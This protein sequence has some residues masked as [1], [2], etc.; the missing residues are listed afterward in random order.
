VTGAPEQRPVPLSRAPRSPTGLAYLLT[1]QLGSTTVTV[2]AATLTKL[3]ETRYL[4]WGKTRYTT[5]DPG[6]PHRFTGQE[7]EPDLGLYYYGARWFDPALGRFISP[8]P[9]VP[10]IGEGNNPNANNSALVVDYHENQYLSQLNQENQARLQNSYIRSPFVPTN[11][12]AFDRYSYTFNNPVRYSDPGGHDPGEGAVGIG[13]L[14]AIGIAFGAPEIII[15]SG[16]VVLTT[17]VVD[18]VTPGA[19]QRHEDIKNSVSQTAANIAAAGAAE[20]AN[21]INVKTQIGESYGSDLY[22][23]AH[24]AEQE[25]VVDLAQEAKKKGGLTQNEADTLVQ[26]GNAAGLHSRGPEVHPNRPKNGPHIH[27]GPIKH[28]PVH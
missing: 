26:W 23:Q 25:A 6:T 24:T 12:L 19:E 16:V 9:I 1:D 21:E 22:L 10:T 8:D 2:D 27:V 18:A 15:I 7:L 28:I 14:A 13:A 17:L 4:P 11:P 3:S 20:Q 5:G